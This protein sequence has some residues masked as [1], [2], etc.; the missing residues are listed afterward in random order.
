MRLLKCS[1]QAGYHSWQQTWCSGV[2]DAALLLCCKLTPS[3]GALLALQCC[4]APCKAKV[5]LPMFFFQ[6][7]NHPSPSLHL[8]HHTV[9]GIS[10]SITPTV[11]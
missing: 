2:R 6:W 11:G 5:H 9:C 7:T 8:L 3:K 10:A 1:P 4:A